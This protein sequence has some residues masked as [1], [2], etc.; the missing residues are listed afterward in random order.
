MRVF[1][2]WQSDL[3]NK[4][5]RGL[6]EDALTR[7]ANSIRK[8][9]SVDVDPI[10]DR[11]TEGVPGSP[12]IADTILAK[13]EAADVVVADVS[14]I[15]HVDPATQIKT[16]RRPT[17]NPNVLIEV[18]YALK[19][20]GPDRLVL[21]M[22]T[23]FGRPEQLPFDLRYR[24]VLPYQSAPDDD[25]RAEA[26]DRL[27]GM[28]ERALLGLPVPPPPPPPPS[29]ADQ[30]RDSI[31]SQRR[32]RAA[33]ARE[34][35]AWLTSEINELAPD[36]AGLLAAGEVVA[37]DTALVDGIAAS[38]QLVATFAR[39]ARD[40]ADHRDGEVAL[41]L[42]QGMAGILVG[43]AEPRDMGGLFYPAQFD[44]HR[45]LGHELMVILLSPLI[46]QREW[47]IVATLLNESLLVSNAPGRIADFSYASGGVAL[48]EL[49]KKRLHSN[50][51]S[52]HFDILLA[53]HTPATGGELASAAPYDEFVDADFFLFLRSVL[54]PNT[55]PEFVPW[56]PWSA[57]VRREPPDFL[58]EA[59]RILAA[60]RLL[61]PLGVP[62][63][64]ELRRRLRERLRMLSRVW[65]SGAHF[66]LLFD[67]S[68]VGTK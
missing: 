59:T 10:I 61:S 50:R 30:L 1:Y 11:D 2:S 17:P 52:L 5:N 68:G 56:S 54:S 63:V 48:L 35:M 20:L 60:E 66:G 34:F 13:I 28:F 26:R 4:T 43:Y 22:N 8:N 58:T 38:S 7:A 25:S 57:L 29:Q 41:A 23:A 47:V 33:R 31:A 32:D 18:G 16:D 6:I 24:R 3:P 39:V 49:R 65:P 46:A 44:Y 64:V 55:A 40:V 14:I 51:A 9:G 15:G 67:A 37:A 36:L 19:A 27:S 62:D 21:V 42:Y 53:R 12:H 45:F